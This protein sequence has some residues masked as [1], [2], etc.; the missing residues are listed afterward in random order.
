MSS[1]IPTRIDSDLVDAAKAAGSIH[2]RTPA[3]Q[4]H[5]WARIGREFESARNVS[6]VEVAKVLAGQA[7]YDALAD[8]EQAVVRATWEERDEATLSTLNFAAEFEAAGAR[9]VWRGTSGGCLVGLAGFGRG[10]DGGVGGAGTHANSTRCKGG[11]RG[12]CRG[13]AE[14]QA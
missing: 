7:S 13:S 4:I 11:N 9:L 2:S 10:R 5:H 6:A 14:A 1:T 12:P 3:Q 8:A